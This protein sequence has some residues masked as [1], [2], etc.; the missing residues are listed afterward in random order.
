MCCGCQ[1]LQDDDYY[2]GSSNGS[3]SH[4]LLTKNIAPIMSETPGFSFISEVAADHFC[5]RC[6]RKEGVNRQRG[7][8]SDVIR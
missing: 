3:S 8:V 1:K 2:Y 7:R 6:T 4:P 5:E